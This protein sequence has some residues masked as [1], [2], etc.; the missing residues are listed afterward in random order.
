MQ[1]LV[2]FSQQI[3]WFLKSL[4][5]LQY[6]CKVYIHDIKVKVPLKTQ[7]FACFKDTCRVL[8]L[9]LKLLNL[10]ENIKNF[11]FDHFCRLTLKTHIFKILRNLTK[12]RGAETLNKKR[13]IY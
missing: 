7:S 2:K 1:I 9:I 3:T 5:M 6:I 13:P 12:Q 8:M 4:W 10:L 11:N